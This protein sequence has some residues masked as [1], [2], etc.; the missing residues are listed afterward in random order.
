[1][2]TFTVSS[3]QDIPREML[4]PLC[5]LRQL[6]IEGTNLTNTQVNN[7]LCEITQR[8]TPD[9]TKLESLNISR[10]VLNDTPSQLLADACLRLTSLNISDTFLTPK[11]CLAIFSALPNSKMTYLDISGVRLISVPTAVLAKGVCSLVEVDLSS[12]MIT[13]RQVIAILTKSKMS[14][15]LNKVVG[16][17]MK[18]IPQHLE[19]C[20]KY[21]RMITPYGNLN[22][23]ARRQVRLREN[24]K[25]GN[26]KRNGRRI[27]PLPERSIPPPLPPQGIPAP[28]PFPSNG[29]PPPPP[30][31]PPPATR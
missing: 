1:M 19:V 4:A 31:P 6:N 30:P 18:D 23:R 11:Q 8:Q 20:A 28:P 2:W 22:L 14:S 25:S 3:L 9:K 21:L 27:Y 10:N 12:T 15:T 13:T 5:K 17:A 24:N 26:I 7:I 29:I 16:I